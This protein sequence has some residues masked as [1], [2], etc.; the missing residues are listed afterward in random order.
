MIYGIQV[1]P[2]LDSLERP[3]LASIILGLFAAMFL[4]RKIAI[5]PHTTNPIQQ[6]KIDMAIFIGG[7]V[8]LA[9]GNYI[10]YDFPLVAGFRV[11]I[12]LTLLG[13]FISLQL[14]L[15]KEQQMIKQS[16]LSSN[17][18]YSSI[19]KRIQAFTFCLLASA[20]VVMILV[21]YKD[22]EWL[23]EVGKQ[24]SFEQAATWILYEF[25]FVAAVF[26][27]YSFY[28]T[29]CFSQNIALYFHHQNSTLAKL[30]EGDRKVKVPITANNEF[31]TMAEYT[32]HMID[33]LSCTETTLENTR[34]AAIL[35]IASLAETRDNETGAHILRTQEYVYA[36]GLYL[37]DNPRFSDELSPENLNLI[38]K[39]APLHD[40]G[41][42]GI[43]DAILLKPGKLTVEEFEVMKS[44]PSIG[45]RALEKAEEQVGEL[46]FLAY[47]KEISESHH[48]KWDGNGYPA[49]LKGDAIPISARLMALAD[50]YDALITKR[51]YKPAFSHEKSRDIILE[52][53][54]KHFDPDIVDAFVAIEHRFLE[55]A[56]QHRDG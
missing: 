39:S 9:T 53:K 51:V 18:S 55:I 28:I 29:R 16:V 15:Q 27:G 11:I 37:Q 35:A 50:V 13:F 22:F 33:S 24:Y 12:G 54:G 14:L 42:V 3:L 30:K 38:Y 31:G 5:N 41:K 36:L 48:E 8:V 46:P 44:H 17:A 21:I 23:K 40:I 6:F 25:L 45:R 4:V 20:M 47:A 43:P 2:F 10:T 1:C 19:A 34:D 7:G 56:K 52:G 32:N 26:S 49:G